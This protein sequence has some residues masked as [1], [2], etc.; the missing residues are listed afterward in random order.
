M[1]KT[2]NS[3]QKMC[4]KRYETFGKLTRVQL[5]RP[6][7]P[8]NE[9]KNH[10]ESVKGRVKLDYETGHRPEELVPEQLAGCDSQLWVRMET[11]GREGERRGEGGEGGEGGGGDGERGESGEREERGRETS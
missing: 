6:V 1:K 2:N 11:P 7:F 5:V 3:G 4:F 10:R 9:N 8:E